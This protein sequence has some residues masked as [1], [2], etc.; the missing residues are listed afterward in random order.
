MESIDKRYD[1]TVYTVFAPKSIQGLVTDYP[2]LGQIDEFKIRKH[3]LLFV[4]YYA[5]KVSPMFSHSSHRSKR[6]KIEACLKVS[7]YVPSHDIKS[8]ILEGNFPTR[9]AGAISRMEDFEPSVRIMAKLDS[10]D[11]YLTLQKLTSLDLDEEGNHATF[12]NKD[13]E[14]NFTAKK[15]YMEMIIK[16]EEKKPGIISQ[17]ENGFGV[18]GVKKGSNDKNYDESGKTFLEAFHSQNN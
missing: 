15:Q 7:G 6:E 13:E 1:D 5:C 9:I 14:I 3:E 18:T 10:M 11:K 2:E 8:K 4:W 16:F 17:I 12:K